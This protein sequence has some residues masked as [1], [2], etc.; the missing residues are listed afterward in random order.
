LHEDLNFHPYKT[1]SVHT[2]YDQDNVSRKIVCEALFNAP[3]NDNLNHVFMMDEAKFQ[4]CENAS[5]QNCQY[6]ATQNPRDN[7]QKPLNSEKVIVWCGVASFGVICPYFF[8]D[9]A[10]GQ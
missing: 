8:E 9:E 4:L 2:I 7:H 5:S 1:V 6:W 10:A 3:D